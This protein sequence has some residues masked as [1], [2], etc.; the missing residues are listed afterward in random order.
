MLYLDVHADEILPELS[1]LQAEQSQLSQPFLIGE[2]LQLFH[3]L[4][5]LSLDSL[6]VLYTD[7]LRTD[8]GKVKLEKI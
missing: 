3:H 5:V 1:F 6:Q 7:V 8:R 2:M 4:H